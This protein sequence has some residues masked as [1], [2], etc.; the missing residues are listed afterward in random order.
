MQKNLEQSRKSAKNKPTRMGRPPKAEEDRLTTSLGG[1]R[2]TQAAYDRLA[3]QAESAGR[4]VADYV[5][6]QLGIAD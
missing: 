2:L 5:R 4:S 3:Q 6:G 1:V